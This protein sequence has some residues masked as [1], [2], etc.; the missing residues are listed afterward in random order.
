MPYFLRFQ[1]KDFNISLKDFKRYGNKQNHAVNVINK[2][3][4]FD[5]MS[6]P[7]DLPNR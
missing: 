4:V 3:V 6:V 2:D 7:K 1:K 5:C